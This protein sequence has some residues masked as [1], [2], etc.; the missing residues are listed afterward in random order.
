LNQKLIF[1]EG[2]LKREPGEAGPI[3][4]RRVGGPGLEGKDVI[5]PA[6]I[7]ENPACR[8]KG[9]GTGTEWE[10]GCIIRGPVGHTSASVRKKRTLGGKKVGVTRIKK[11]QIRGETMTVKKARRELNPAPPVTAI[12]ED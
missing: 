3:R 9:R 4:E 8:T 12:E 11:A 6:K 5:H 1:G 2:I 10:S 7:I